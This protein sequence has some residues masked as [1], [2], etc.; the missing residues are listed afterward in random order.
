MK[1]PLLGFISSFTEDNGKSSTQE[2][3]L[4][5]RSTKKIKTSL[6]DGSS[7][8]DAPVDDNMEA[9]NVEGEE[10]TVE[11]DP[12]TEN[13]PKD[14]T[15]YAATLMKPHGPIRETVFVEENDDLP[16]NKWYSAME[17][18]DE[19]P[20]NLSESCPDKSNALAHSPCTDLNSMPMEQVQKFGGEEDADVSHN[21]HIDDAN[22]APNQSI[23]VEDAPPSNKSSEFGPWMLA[24]KLLKIKPKVNTRGESLPKSHVNAA[25]STRFEALNSD[26]EI[27][28]DNSKEVPQDNTTRDKD[29]LKVVDIINHGKAAAA[30]P[31]KSTRIRNATG[32][33]NPQIK[34]KSVSHGNKQVAPKAKQ[35]DTTTV[36]HK[37][38]M[39]EKETALEALENT[40]D[41]YKD[42]NQIVK[43][44]EK[45]ILQRMKNFP[46][47]NSTF[48]NFLD[49]HTIHINNEEVE[50][51]MKAHQLTKGSL[52]PKPPD[53]EMSTNLNSTMMID[54]KKNNM[55]VLNES[56][57]DMSSGGVVSAPGHAQEKAFIASLPEDGR[58]R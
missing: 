57:V 46:V 6:V 48:M 5:R 14:A 34:G 9:V 12:V 4:K 1:N 26:M 52:N 18:K 43:E 11:D 28:L 22:Q 7:I 8:P 42:A 31:S 27:S 37:E 41:H 49:A 36:N 53:K 19:E 25:A 24:K 16:E 51:A 55:Q 56:E 21:M 38:T 3:D 10:I 40:K 2:E 32:G 33:K 58:W 35:K 39:K 20:F 54:L 45:V 47:T 30:N 44:R 13:S 50:F 17:T 15:S 23:N 29:N